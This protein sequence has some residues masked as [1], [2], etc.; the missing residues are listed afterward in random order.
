MS[1]L[2]HILHVPIAETRRKP[3]GDPRWCFGCRTVRDFEH[4]ISVPVC[5]TP[6]DTGC[7][8]GPSHEVVCATC[9]L[10]DGDCFPGTS[11]EWSDE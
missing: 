1:T 2:I 10:V 3:D 5:E 7:W 6:D 4:V 8:Y 9:G 11:R